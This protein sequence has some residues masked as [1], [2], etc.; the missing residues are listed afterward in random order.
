MDAVIA[1]AIAAIIGIVVLCLIARDISREIQKMRNE[2]PSSARL[3][4]SLEE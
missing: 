1:I 3:R 4:A 2:V